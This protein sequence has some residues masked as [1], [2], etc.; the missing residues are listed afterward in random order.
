MV[1]ELACILLT[2][3]APETL[4]MDAAAI[5]VK[6]E[7]S[8]GSSTEADLGLWKGSSS[9][10]VGTLNPPVPLL[11][12]SAR[13]ISNG[14]ASVSGR[15]CPHI[16]AAQDG[17][18]IAGIAPERGLTK[19]LDELEAVFC[20]PGIRSDTTA[21][22][23]PRKRVWKQS[24][25]TSLAGSAL[26]STIVTSSSYS[27]LEQ[28]YA[29]HQPRMNA[30]HI[31][32]MMKKLARFIRTDNDL[33]T[34]PATSALIRKAE[35][36]LWDTLLD[37]AMFLMPS[38]RCQQ[39]V[40]SLSAVH[41]V[42]EFRERRHLGWSRALPPSS[43]G[44][45]NADNDNNSF[46]PTDGSSDGLSASVPPPIGLRPLHSSRSLTRPE[47]ELVR[48]ALEHSQSL[49]LEMAA[50]QATDSSVLDLQRLLAAVGRLGM[51]PGDGWQ[52]AFFLASERHMPIM[53]RTKIVAL[54]CGV[55]HLQPA[56]K[57]SASWMNEFFSRSGRIMQ[58]LEP[59]DLST[60]STAV[61]R[62]PKP[63]PDNWVQALL[64]RSTECLDSFDAPAYAL[65]LHSVG[66]LRK[67]PPKAWVQEVLES[68][69]G[70]LYD[71]SP[72]GRVCVL[73]SR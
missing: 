50:S 70:L 71:F 65:V 34:S 67:R 16:L 44:Q 15:P 7:A 31:A 1:H 42:S 72:G 9:S 61:S 3:I 22:G 41:L 18:V 52:G 4:V 68:S 20:G 2:Q 54:A 48:L 62:L 55:S 25:G 26:L 8:S 33:N 13:L 10:I 24:R 28:L 11:L 19:L 64:Q 12:N 38:A 60:I 39:V 36:Q 17:P 29:E 47:R 6:N 66:R 57:P 21:I 32:A 14:E 37:K 73:S 30:V 63:Y 69:A 27:N 56:A 51:A 23:T 45:L 49:L 59:R 46:D 53:D 43:E 35:A 5:K 58:T 40:V